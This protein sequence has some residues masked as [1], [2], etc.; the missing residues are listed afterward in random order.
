ML[1]WF[2]MLRYGD[3]SASLPVETVLLAL[4]VAFVIG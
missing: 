2:D 1:D 3:P 4:L